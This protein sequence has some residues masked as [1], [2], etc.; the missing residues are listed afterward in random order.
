MAWE[1]APDVLIEPLYAGLPNNPGLE[2]RKLLG[3]PSACV[4]G[5]MFIGF[6]ENNVVVGISEKIRTEPAGI[7][8]VCE[9]VLGR[10]MKKAS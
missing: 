9:A 4:N 7:A 1:K 3:Y 8:N 5:N 2:R 10:K 6:Y